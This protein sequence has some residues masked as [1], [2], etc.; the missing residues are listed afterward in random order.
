MYT[1][2]HPALATSN[3]IIALAEALSKLADNLHA[4][5][6]R[7]TAQPDGDKSIAYSLL[8]EEYALRARTNILRNDAPRHTMEGL[9]FCQAS[10][11]QTLSQI[12]AS[13]HEAST[14]EVVRSI[15]SDLITFAS[16]INPGKARIVNFLAKE[17]GV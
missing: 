11:M 5:L 14:L 8:T 12:G 1:D 10:L 7:L 16:A 9:N 6:R 13:L 17:F 4:A 15:A 3:D 2:K